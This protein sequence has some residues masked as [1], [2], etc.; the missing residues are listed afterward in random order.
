MTDPTPGPPPAGASF[1]TLVHADADPAPESL[2]RQTPPRRWLLPATTAVLAVL[3]AG[4]LVAA[5]L[6]PG[7]ST[8]D[9]GPVSA[10]AATPGASPSSTPR[11]TLAAD[12]A[13]LDGAG[14]VAEL[15]DPAWVARIAAAGNIPERA[16]AAYAGAALAVAET[17]PGCG[18]GWNTLAAIGHVESEHGTIGGSRTARNGV[19]SP[20]IIGI[21]LDGTDSMEIRDTD[22]GELDGDTTWDRAVGPMQFIPDTWSQYAQDG[23]NDG[24]AD[25]HQIDDAALTAAVYL[26]TAGGDL[27]DSANW[28]TAIHAYNPSVEYNNRVAE[29]AT[30]YTTLR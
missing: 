20:P 2:E 8:P 4:A 18:L 5:A 21:P 6:A 28:I 17:H 30:H 11:P 16:L 7:L 10:P 13:G 27:T 1:D 3:G 23:N 15:A 25:V 19:A 14:V 24:Q 22:G 9:P 29:A 12:G 26:C